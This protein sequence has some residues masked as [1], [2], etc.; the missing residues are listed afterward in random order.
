MLIPEVQANEEQLQTQI[1]ARFEAAA[2]D[3]QS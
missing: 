1:R 2:K 3:T